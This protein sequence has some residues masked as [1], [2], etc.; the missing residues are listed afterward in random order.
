MLKQCQQRSF[1]RIKRHKVNVIKDA[2]FCQFTQ[3]G[4]DKATTQGNVNMRVFV[5]DALRNSESGV[6]RAWKRHR[7][8]DQRRLV[9]VDGCKRQGLQ[10]LVHQ[11]QGGCKSGRQ[12]LKGGLATGQ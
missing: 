11:G 2:G 4:I 5:L 10:R 9:L 7:Q 8:Q 12:G 6:H 1:A 3:L